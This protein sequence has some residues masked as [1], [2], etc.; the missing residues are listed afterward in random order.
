MKI[1][2]EKLSPSVF[3]DIE[4]E[5][6]CLLFMAGGAGNTLRGWFTGTLYDYGIIVGWRA[7]IDADESTFKNSIYGIPGEFLE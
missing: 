2:I 3:L 7:K 1:E 4:G 6:D 5:V